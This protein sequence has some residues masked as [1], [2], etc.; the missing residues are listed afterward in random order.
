MNAY[1]QVPHS[2]TK[3]SLLVPIYTQPHSSRHSRSSSTSTVVASDSTPASPIADMDTLHYP[4]TL[5]NTPSIDEPTIQS[6][7][8]PLFYASS[9]TMTLK[10]PIVHHKNGHYKTRPSIQGPATPRRDSL[11]DLNSDIDNDS[12]NES[13][14]SRTDFTD[15]YVA[16]MPTWDEGVFAMDDA[17]VPQ[18]ANASVPSTAGTLSFRR[19]RPEPWSVRAANTHNS[20]DAQI[21]VID[22]DDDEFYI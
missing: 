11:Y 6:P 4:I 16:A 20:Y 15:S 8:S 12:D 22:D 9:H 2:C 18:V 3:E 1:F 19:S 17:E 13:I 7:T 21:R 14:D 5:P 10:V